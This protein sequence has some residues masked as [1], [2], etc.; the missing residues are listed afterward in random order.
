MTSWLSGSADLC[1]P[2][3]DLL[4]KDAKV[5]WTAEQDQAL[6][7]LKEAVATAPCLRQIIAKKPVYVRCDASDI[8]CAC[9][10]YQ[11]VFNVQTKQ[12]E[13]QAIAYA[14]RRFS[15]AERRWCLAERESYSIKANTATAVMSSKKKTNGGASPKQT[16]FKKGCH[17][18]RIR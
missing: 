9:V 18:S 8:G 12:E 3:F 1:A 10:L 13:P 6:R 11:M 7:L 5:Q 17:S 15:P 4:K 16:K 2:L 14:T